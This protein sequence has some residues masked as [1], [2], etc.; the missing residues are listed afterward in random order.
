V[1]VRSVNISLPKQV[2][3]KD[4]TVS[5]G[6]FKEPVTGT[7]HI[8]QFNLTGDQQV[9]LKNHGG[10]HKAVY[11]FSAD[12][13][14]FWQQKLGLNSLSYGQFGENLT[15]SGL[16]ESLL[17]IG[18][19][20]QVGDSVLEITQPRVPCFKLGIAF[21]LEAMPRLFVENAAT[22]I[23]FRV[24]E[25]GAVVA[26]D[27]VKL[28]TAHPTQLR[29]QQLFRAYFDKTMSADEKRTSFEQALSIPALSEEWRQKVKSRL[30]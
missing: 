5:T 26:G 15:I 9:D 13:Y 4:K 19:Q 27:K 24:I 3:Y 7:V 6:I 11:A 22:G 25:T 10:E 30:A 14:P 17:S 29:V 18:D 20:L 28:K 23:Y 21:G 2:Q 1:I 16:D 8:N 12:H